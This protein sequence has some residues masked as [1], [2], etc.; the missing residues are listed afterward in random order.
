M[1]RSRKSVSSLHFLRLEDRLTPSF[2]P[3]TDF[4]NFNE[5]S[6]THFG[7]SGGNDVANDVIVDD[8]GRIVMAGYAEVRDNTQTGHH[9]AMAMVRLNSDGIRDMTFGKDGMVIIDAV[10]IHT[11]SINVDTSAANSLIDTGSGYLVAGFAHIN[12]DDDIVV[13]SVDY[14][15]NM[16]GRFGNDL[17]GLFIRN[18]SQYDRA[19]QIVQDGSNYAIAATVGA[20]FSSNGGDIACLMINSAGQSVTT[21]G[22]NGVFKINFGG[23]D[24]PVG[25]AVKPGGQIILGGTATQANGTKGIAGIQLTANGL[26]DTTF[27]TTGYAFYP[28]PG[29]IA[30]DA[31]LLGDN[32]IV[33][34]GSIPN[35][36]N[37]NAGRD[38]FTAKL[39]PDGSLDSTLGLGGID[40]VDLGANNDEFAAVKS[41]GNGGFVC[42]GR[43]QSHTSKA[44]YDFAVLRYTATGQHDGAF[45]SGGLFTKDYFHDHNI[46]HAVAVDGSGRVVVAGESDFKGDA[47]FVCFRLQENADNSLADSDGDGLPDLWET[48]GKGLDVNGDGIIDLDLYAMGARPNHKDLFLEVDTMVGRSNGVAAALATMTTAFA[49]SPPSN[50]DT[51]PGIT[52]HATLDETTIPLA[53]WANVTNVFPTQ[54]DIVKQNYFG[55]A[56]QRNDP[57]WPNI[58]RALNLVERYCVI[59]DRF[60]SQ[61][62]SGI[63]RGL[64]GQDFLVT[65]GNQYFYTDGS[66]AP[67]PSANMLVG[68]IMHEFGHTLG[69]RH[70]GTINGIN[71]NPNYFS[72]MNYRFQ[73]GRNQT[74]KSDPSKSSFLLS[75]FPNYSGNTDPTYDNWSNIVYPFRNGG[76]GAL[77]SSTDKPDPEGDEE[78]SYFASD[79]LTFAPRTFAAAGPGIAPNVLVLDATT[80]QTLLTIPAFESTFTGGVRI[81]SAD[82]NGDGYADVVAGSGPG[83]STLVRLFDGVTGEQLIEIAPF[84]SSFTGGVFVALADYNDDG[85]PDLVITPDEGGGPRVRVLNGIDG[86]TINDFFGIEDTNFRGGARCTTGDVNGDGTADLLVAAG[87][88]GGPRV[89]VF[90][91]KSIHLPLS[92]NS[93]PPKL[94]GDFFAFENN[95]RNGV[96]LASGD[97]NN[98]G[99]DDVIF[100]AGPG[101]GPRVMISSGP[102]ILADPTVAI[103]TP[104]ANFFAG[105]TNSRAGIHVT[106]ANADWDDGIDVVTGAANGFAPHLTTYTAA[107][108]LAHAVPAAYHDELLFDPNILSGVFVG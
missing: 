46:A 97:V 2:Q 55:T 66:P 51:V 8:F 34:V 83:R 86:S 59:A 41:T 72:I 81:A 49:N 85:V 79:P 40:I 35:P 107:E 20:A 5:I 100:G 1:S 24:R 96:F 77:G 84:E 6:R 70:G 4:N 30:N 39:K 19:F 65:L 103:N 68:T 95:L 88:G 76:P 105:D 56:A 12:G 58:S 64:P 90:D 92:G 99:S 48:K 67:G 13:G 50:P 57:N 17:G 43:T 69:Q 80:D 101:G 47:D 27:H 73:M 11:G 32:S 54:F 16:N 31:I 52:L 78:P 75:G 60:G 106:V 104:L 37:T 108:L 33:I 14:K 9:Q 102:A 36:F 3:Q 7:V 93:M 18:V 74:N 38:A 26:L 23:D 21:F 98:D 87:F 63:A 61:N 91:G 62:N 42:V 25:M 71:Y 53:S 15:G 10:A 94:V 45:G 44:D 89:A 28:T 29:V 22:Q 82:V